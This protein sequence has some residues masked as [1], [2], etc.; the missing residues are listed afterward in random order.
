D[1]HRT[2]L[3]AW[4]EIDDALNGYASYR[5]QAQKQIERVANAKEAYSLIQVKYEA[6]TVDFLSVLDSQRTYLQARR[7]LVSSQGQLDIQYVA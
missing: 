5:Q 1:Y 6:G 4:Q 2:V 7:D 3:Q